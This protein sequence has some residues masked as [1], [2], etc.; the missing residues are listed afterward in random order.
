MSRLLD[1]SLSLVDK[2]SLLSLSSSEGKEFI[3]DLEEKKCT[4]NNLIF[5]ASKTGDFKR[6]TY[7]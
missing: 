7:A 1:L 2:V 4:L 6:L 5:G 3:F